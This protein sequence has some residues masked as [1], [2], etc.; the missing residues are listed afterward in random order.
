MVHED[1]A[2]KELAS[3][4]WPL[5]RYAERQAARCAGYLSNNIMDGLSPD[6]KTSMRIEMT[7]YILRAVK[8]GQRHPSS[9]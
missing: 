4:K 7:L 8:Y 9:K 6:E 3:H 5:E 2:W 1:A